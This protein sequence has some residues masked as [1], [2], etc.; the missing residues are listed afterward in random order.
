MCK[1]SRG[2]CLIDSNLKSVWN[3]A[4]VLQDV[5]HTVPIISFFS[6]TNTNMEHV[7]RKMSLSGYSTSHVQ[8]VVC[9]LWAHASIHTQI[10]S[11]PTTRKT[12]CWSFTHSLGSSASQMG[13]V[14]LS[15]HP[16]VYCMQRS[17]PSLPNPKIWVH[18]AA[19]PRRSHACVGFWDKFHAASVTQIHKCKLC[20]CPSSGLLLKLLSSYLDR[21]TADRR[22]STRIDW[23]SVTIWFY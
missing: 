22:D 10:W 8:W 18:Q 17:S 5:L 4:E 7:W 14:C 3:S 11:N 6:V 15:L 19:D 20:S 2:W 21:F 1:W 13:C 9:N 23:F 16:A 12:T